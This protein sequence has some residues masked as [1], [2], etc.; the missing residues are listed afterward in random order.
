ML[1]IETATD[2]LSV[3]IVMDDRFVAERSVSGKKLHSVRLIPF[4]KNVLT[5]AALTLEDL[6]GI[7]VSSG[8]GSFTGIRLGVATAR[9]LA[10]VLDLPVV[11][12]STLLALAAPLL[13]GGIPVCAVIVS[14]RDEVY[15]GVYQAA[16]GVPSA[17]VPAFAAAPADAAHRLESF[18]KVILAGEGAH[19]FRKTFEDTLGSRS[20]FAPEA[21]H[22]QGAVIAGLGLKELTSAGGAGYSVLLPEYLRPPAIT[23]GS[24]PDG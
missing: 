20:L 3:G 6:D 14:R 5:D 11:G 15:A 10:Q 19:A 8:P 4:I 17:V 9:T 23:G 21:A 13:T 2:V 24:Y 18:H 22:P 16:G 12:I 1:G 7:A